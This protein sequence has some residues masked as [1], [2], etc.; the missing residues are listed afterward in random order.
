MNGRRPL[1]AAFLVAALLL[2][3][4]CSA[5]RQDDLVLEPTVDCE[6]EALVRARFE[7]WD[8]SGEAPFPETDFAKRW[9]FGKGTPLVNWSGCDKSGAN[10]RRADLVAA[11]LSRTN[12]VGA[13][14]TDADLGVADLRG[15]NLQDA[16]LANANLIASIL[17]GTNLSGANLTNANLL[18]TRLQGVNLSGA[19]WIDGTTV[20]AP[21]SVD[22]CEP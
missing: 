4:G 11:N 8:L 21:G 16:R 13:D 1:G 18:V 14:L 12:L 20:C 19:R 17:L 3:A 10:L 6:Q 2:S 9:V 22:I 5:F 15:A 7:Y